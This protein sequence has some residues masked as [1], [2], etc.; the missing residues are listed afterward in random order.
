MEAV[1]GRVLTPT[2]RE[3][4]RVIADPRLEDASHVVMAVGMAFLMILLI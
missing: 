2:G 1:G 4:I 3:A